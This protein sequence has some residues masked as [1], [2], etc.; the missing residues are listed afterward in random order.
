MKGDG[1]DQPVLGLVTVADFY[2]RGG[3]WTNNRRWRG[4]VYIFIY[5]I[6]KRKN[7]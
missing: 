7:K 6:L 1:D 2:H 4:V 5:I 3:K